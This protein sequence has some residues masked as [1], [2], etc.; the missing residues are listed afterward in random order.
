MLPF[1]PKRKN[2]LAAWMAARSDGE[3]YGQ[4]LVYRFPK[5]KLIYGPKQ[6]V[7][8]INQDPEISRQT[9]ALEPARLAGHLGHPAGDPDQGIAHLCAAALS[10]GGVRQDPRAQ[11]SDCG[12]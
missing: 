6:I 5:Q 9:L 3:H 2:N 7:A 10:A 1:T 11:A 8:R 4:L 12:G